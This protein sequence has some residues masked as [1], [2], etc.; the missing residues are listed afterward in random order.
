V[1]V[2]IRKIKQFKPIIFVLPALIFYVLFFV[3][4]I[5]RTVQFSFYNW[6]GASPTMSFVGFENYIRMIN[7]PIFWKSL[8]HNIFWI[9][10]TIVLPVGLGLILAVLL[11][12]KMVKGKLLFRVTYFMPVIVSLVAVGIIWNWIYHPDFGIVNDILRTVGLGSLAQPWLGNENTVLPALI[13]AGSWTYYGFCMVIFLAAIQGIDKSYYEAAQIEGASPYQSF[14]Y[15]TIPLLKN[16]ITLLVLNSLIGSFKVF[17][18][19]FLMT[20]GGPYHSSEVIGTYMFNQAFAMND[21]GYGAAISIAL[22][23]VIA[24]CSITYMRFAERSD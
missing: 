7:D 24:V 19:I 3:L 16:T 6:D 4:P 15:V 12:N 20:K 22:S 1:Q 10:S 5:I 14:I 9:I 23:L 18:L 8:S 11:S 21:V 13:V 2:A 17:D